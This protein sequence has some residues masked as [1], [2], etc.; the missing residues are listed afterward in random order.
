MGGLADPL[1]PTS[2]RSGRPL[3]IT[4][5][6]LQALQ[7]ATWSRRDRWRVF[8]PI[9]SAAEQF[10]SNAGRLPD[11]LRG[12]EQQNGLQPYV[13]GKI[14]DLRLWVELGLAADHADFIDFISAFAAEHPATRAR[15]D[16][17]FL[18]DKI[19]QASIDALVTLLDTIPPEDLQ[20]TKN[21]NSKAYEAILTIQH[22]YVLQLQ[23]RDLIS[24]R[25]LTDY[26]A[27]ARLSILTN[28]VETT[29][30]KYRANDARYL[31]GE[32]CWRHG[33]V[34][35]ARRWWATLDARDQRDEYVNEYTDIAAELRRSGG[36]PLDA[37]FI[38]RILNAERGRWLSF[39]ATRLR[40]FG[41]HF[42]T[43]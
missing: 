10:D 1:R 31:I 40:Q 3:L 19:A 5:A 30:D 17:L 8:P 20:W 24:R 12:Y 33:T 14:R 6:R 36:A 18:L 23:R 25:A 21:A 29:P 7:D 39:S 38:N 15:T 2:P 11:L 37:Q 32:I 28:I 35:D 22:Y 43:F 26:Y 13:D 16:L 27:T 34:D 42:D 41:Y 4:D 9:A